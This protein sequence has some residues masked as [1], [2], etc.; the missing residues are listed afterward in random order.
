MSNYHCYEKNHSFHYPVFFAISLHSGRSRP[1]D[2]RG[3]GGGH[4][5][6]EIR[7]GP[8]LQKNS[9]APSR[10]ILVKK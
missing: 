8:G 6:P 3:G 7:G 1:S 9:F 5:D 4:P 2:S 10:L